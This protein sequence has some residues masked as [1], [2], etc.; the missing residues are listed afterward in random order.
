MIYYPEC[1]K[2]SNNHDEVSAILDFLEWL[3]GE[4]IQLG[5]Y[6]QRGDLM[7][8]MTPIAESAQS[9]VYRF[10]DID[11]VKLEEERRD[12]LRRLND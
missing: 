1:T 5:K 3:G 9:L 2:L 4:K 10:L 12:M 7:Y 6:G 8:H 11:P